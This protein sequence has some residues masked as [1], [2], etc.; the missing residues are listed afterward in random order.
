MW[1][2]FIT[3]IRMPV[4]LQWTD[5]R[6]RAAFLSFTALLI[7]DAVLYG[8]LLAPAAS[9]LSA[10]EARYRALRK[11]H[12]E[13]VL[14][15]KQKASFSGIMAGTPSQKDMPLL[16]K[17]LVQTARQLGLSVSSVKYDIPKA[18]GEFTMLAFSFPAEGQYANIKRFIHDVETSDRLVGIQD[19]KMDSD[20]GSVRMEMRLLTYIRGQQVQ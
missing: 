8:A 20:K 4:W 19:L 2:R 14:F 9:Q 6:L 18:S 3:N 16:V 11:R 13:A 7:L 1:S 12:A 17:N 15:T 5:K 10:G